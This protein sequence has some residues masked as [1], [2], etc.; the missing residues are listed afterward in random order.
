MWEKPPK[1]ASVIWDTYYEWDDKKWINTRVDK[2]SLDSAY[3]VYEVH[4]GSWRRDPNDDGRRLSY[5]EI[6]RDL[7]PYVKEMGFT[8]VELMP[9]M[10]HPYEPSW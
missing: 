10:H 3:S 6:A 5:R 7:V 4:L 1:T 9:I 8:H 2:N